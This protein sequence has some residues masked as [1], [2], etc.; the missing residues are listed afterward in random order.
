MTESNPKVKINIKKLCN[1]ASKILNKT[2]YKTNKDTI[3]TLFRRKK[4]EVE[5]K[6][7][8]IMRLRLIDSCYSTNMAKNPGGFDVLANKIEKNKKLLYDLDEFLKGDGEDI[9]NGLLE[10]FCSKHGKNR[11]TSLISKYAYFLTGHEFPIYDRLVSKCY[12]N[13][14]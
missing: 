11:T 14:P 5:N 7:T 6:N 3:D 2:A 4:N 9:D 1:N 12:I 13:F 8:I 10:L